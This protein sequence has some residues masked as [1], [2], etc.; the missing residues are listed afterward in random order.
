MFRHR[1]FSPRPRLRPMLMA[2]VQRFPWVSGTILG[3]DVV[4]D[5]GNIRAMSL[6]PGAPLSDGQDRLGP[7]NANSP[8]SASW[9]GLSSITGMPCRSATVLASD[10]RP[11]WTISA[12]ILN[13]VRYGSYSAER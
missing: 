2:E 6:E 7:R 5:V 12:P 1:S 13:C 4:P 3:R 11:V 9:D 8:A 10:S